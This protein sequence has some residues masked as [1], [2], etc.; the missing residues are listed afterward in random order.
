MYT[1]NL[2]GKKRILYQGNAGGIWNQQESYNA[3]Q[4]KIWPTNGLYI[5]A[6]DYVNVIPTVNPNSANS[7]AW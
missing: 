5:I 3:T 2:I 1:G 6:Q 7:G 4:E